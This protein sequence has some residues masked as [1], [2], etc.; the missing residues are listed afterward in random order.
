M[1]VSFEGEVMRALSLEETTAG[2]RLGEARAVRFHAM[3]AE[4]EA[5]EAAV[6]VLSLYGPD[7]EIDAGHTIRIGFA[8]ESFATFRAVKSR[9]AFDEIGKPDWPGVR[10]LKL[11]GVEIDGEPV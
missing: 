1:I 10:R 6:D 8:A 7:A 11:T 2:E 4:I 5:A 9:G 3:L